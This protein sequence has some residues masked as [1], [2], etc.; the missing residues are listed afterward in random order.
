MALKHE[1]SHYTCTPNIKQDIVFVLTTD[2]VSKNWSVSVQSKPTSVTLMTWE[3]VRG[4]AICSL[5]S[6]QARH[7]ACEVVASTG[8]YTSRMKF[9]AVLGGTH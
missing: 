4:C 8:K 3:D 1:R 7:Y 2:T 5:R 9:I 6:T